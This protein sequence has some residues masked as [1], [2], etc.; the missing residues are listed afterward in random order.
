MG[1]LRG[2]HKSMRLS[3]VTM[4]PYFFAYYYSLN[5]ILLPKDAKSIIYPKQ[6]TAWIKKIRTSTLVGEAALTGAEIRGVDT[7]QGYYCSK[8]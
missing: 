2:S 5:C 3:L 4:N 7:R 1:L 8:H 6:V